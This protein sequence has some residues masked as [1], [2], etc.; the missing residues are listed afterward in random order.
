MIVVPQTGQSSYPCPPPPVLPYITNSIR[1]AMYNTLQ[2]PHDVHT[3]RRDNKSHQ[4][5]ITESIP[6]TTP[7]ER[8]RFFA[9]DSHFLRKMKQEKGKRKHVGPKNRKPQLEVK[10]TKK[11]THFDKSPCRN[12]IFLSSRQTSQDRQES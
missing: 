11:K 8:C 12:F 6:S 10:K 4:P 5:Y 1:T 7:T 2:K 3:V 9:T